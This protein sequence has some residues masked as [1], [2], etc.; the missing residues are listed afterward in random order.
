MAKFCLECGTA[1]EGAKFCPECGIPTGGEGTAPA[2][3]VAPDTASAEDSPVLS[4]TTGYILAAFL[5]IG[6][7]LAGALTVHQHRYES[8]SKGM[9][10][11]CTRGPGDSLNNG[12]SLNK[13]GPFIFHNRYKK[14]WQDPITLII[15]LAG[16]GGAT[17]FV[18]SA[19]RSTKGLSR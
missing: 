1:T 16:I 7:A 19:L 14:D 12:D 3:P 13:C 2:S 4:R 11:G 17:V 10:A 15:A 18:V 6:V 8:T 9:E 5:I